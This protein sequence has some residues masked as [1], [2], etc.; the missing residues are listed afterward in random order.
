MNMG[1][2]I[3]SVIMG[4]FSLTAVYSQH[5]LINYLESDIQS[6]HIKPA[7]IPDSTLTIVF[8]GF[9][10]SIS[11]N[12][13]KLGNIITQN[14]S[15]NNIVDVTALTSDL[16]DNNS[17]RGTF[18]RPMGDLYFKKGGFVVSAGYGWRFDGQLNYNKTLG[19]MY[20]FGN[21]RFIDEE[22]EVSPSF[23]MQSFHEFKLGLAKSFNRFSFGV[24]GKFLSGV[25]NIST[26]QAS[27]KVLT[28][29]DIYQLSFNNDLVINSS[30]IIDYTA[31]DDIDITTRGFSYSNFYS[32][33]Y[34]MV[35]DVGLDAQLSDR[36]GVSLSVLDIGSINWDFQTSN[37]TSKG[38]SE[39]EGVDLINYIG[40]TTSIALEDSLRTVLDIVETNESF[41]TALPMKLYFGTNYQIDSTLRLGALLFYESLW[42]S[43]SYAI[44]VNGTKT[45]GNNIKIGA[46]YAY[47][48]ESPLNLGLS[49]SINLRGICI[50]AASDNIIGLFT[51]TKS[52][53]SN[54]RLKMALKI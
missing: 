8:P 12:G 34:G 54:V 24:K 50:M 1:R 11:Q 44:A 45:F 7:F 26:D 14:A 10:Y 25:E 39:Y 53:L 16:K 17:L 21:A 46:Q 49:T 35:F 15:G 41:T 42:E 36:L 19:E 3:I 13:P 33:N 5:D 30:R 51:P 38:E 4:L 31:I 48:K 22:V 29:G 47:T 40:D 18:S 23:S 32:A 6:A 37:L 9:G 52:G 43:S 2:I 27:V 28:S 20:A